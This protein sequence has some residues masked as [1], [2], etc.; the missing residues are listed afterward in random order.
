ML[1]GTC[2][3]ADYACRRPTAPSEHRPISVAVSVKLGM[4]VWASTSGSNVPGSLCR[5]RVI[6]DF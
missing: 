1:S 2:R 3:P 5:R 4:L 6:S